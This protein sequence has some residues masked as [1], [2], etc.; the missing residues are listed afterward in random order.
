[1]EPI[2]IV[3][4]LIIVINVYVSYKGLAD[5]QF[6]DD[7]S[8]EVDKVLIGQDYKRLIT[9]GFLHVNWMHLLLNMASLYAFSVGLEQ[10]LGASNFLI[11][12]FGSLIGGNLFSLFI[13]RHHGDY[14]AV[15]ASGAMCGVI[16]A[17]I[18]IFPGMSIGFL[19]VSLYIPAWLYGILFVLYSIYGIKSKSDNIGHEAH[20]G[21]ALVGM[22]AAIIMQPASLIQNYLPIILIA[23]PSVFF[24]YM[25]IKRPEFLLIDNYFSNTHKYYSVED[26]YNSNKNS[27]QK[28]IDRILEKI[29]EKG[30]DRLTKSERAF[31]EGFAGKDSVKEGNR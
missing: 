6:F 10:F 7:Y 9:S 20:L 23:V 8:F 3:S 21:G 29:N 5:H 16:F 19:C 4:L 30:I 2:G 15:G 24:I 1:M 12:Y 31:L 28:E 25:I 22:I 27:K 26:K 11:I 14:S 13:H 18:A 17:A